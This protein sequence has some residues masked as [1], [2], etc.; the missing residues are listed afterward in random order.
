[1]QQMG[2]AQ[3][4]TA[5]DEQRVACRAGGFGD[6]D[7]GS[8]CEA[9]VRAEG[10]CLEGV[11][12]YERAGHRPTRGSAGRP[13]PVCRDGLGHQALDADSCKT[14]AISRQDHQLCIPPIT[15]PTLLECSSTAVLRARPSPGVTA[16]RDR[17]RSPAG[18]RGK[19]V[20]GPTD[21][22]DGTCGVVRV[23]RDRLPGREVVRAGGTRV[24][25]IVVRVGPRADLPGR[26]QFA[27]PLC[28][29]HR[30]SGGFRVGSRQCHGNLRK[31]CRVLWQ[32]SATATGSGRTACGAHRGRCDPGG[33]GPV[34][35]HND[36]QR[37]TSAC[38]CRWRPRRRPCPG[39]PAAP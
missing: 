29:T 4:E 38:S 3:A 14:R 12:R 16:L 6:R 22:G 5:V 33:A 19:V 32:P 11:P 25:F 10:E 37:R 20:S 9:V 13:L 28:V 26:R 21:A 7:R 31:R 1:M 34:P 36:G 27:G 30:R 24:A 17:G 15:S 23:L 18:P 39:S 8:V 2:P 35:G